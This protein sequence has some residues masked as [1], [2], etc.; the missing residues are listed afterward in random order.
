MR[1]PKYVREKLRLLLPEIEI[2]TYDQAIR[3]LNNELEQYQLNGIIDDD[4]I[5]LTQMVVTFNDDF[6]D[7]DIVDEEFCSYFEEEYNDVQRLQDDIR[8]YQKQEEAVLSVKPQEKD[9]KDLQVSR[10]KGHRA[11]IYCVEKAVAEKC[12]NYYVDV[13]ISGIAICD[14]RTKKNILKYGELFEYN[15]VTYGSLRYYRP[16]DVNL[17]EE[18]IGTEFVYRRSCRHEPGTQVVRLAYYKPKEVEKIVTRIYSYNEK[19]L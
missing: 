5:T 1:L 12:P 16:N 14:K 8:Q 4:I 15:T 9:R 6:G 11:R 18:I 19:Q 7:T 13:L 3:A 10:Y 2:E 17:I